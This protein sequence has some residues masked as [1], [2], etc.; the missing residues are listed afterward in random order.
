MRVAIGSDLEAM[1]AISGACG[2]PPLSPDTL[3]RCLG[4]IGDH[5][6]FLLDMQDLKTAIVHTAITPHGRGWWGNQFFQAFLRWAFTATRV[7]RINAC[8]PVG[9][10]HIKRFGL[11]AGMRSVTETDTYTFLDIDILR[12][13]SRSDECL[14]EGVSAVSDYPL[15]DAEMVKRVSGVCSM[16]HETGMEHKAWYIYELYAKL[17]GYRVEA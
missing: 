10:R 15:A 4:F 12:W 3:D 1:Q 13:V 17:F 11:E 2:L 6:Y 7:E 8:I 9:D 16:M 14:Q 5:G